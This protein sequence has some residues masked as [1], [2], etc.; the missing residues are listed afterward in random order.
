MTRACHQGHERGAEKS[1]KVKKPVRLKSVALPPR[2][3]TLPGAGSG[4]N[5]ARRSG[6]APNAQDLKTEGGNG[7]VPPDLAAPAPSTGQERPQLL[8]AR[9]APGGT[10]Y[11]VLQGSRGGRP[12]SSRR[13]APSLSVSSPPARGLAPQP[14]PAPLVNY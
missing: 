6:A 12:S 3:E 11:T 13:A 5:P 9:V 7:P 10:A 1:R 8:F 2:A 14:N 4:T